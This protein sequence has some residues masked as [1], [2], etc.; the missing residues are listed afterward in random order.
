MEKKIKSTLFSKII[1][2]IVLTWIC[3]HNDDV[4]TFNKLWYNNYTYD[5]KLYRETYRLLSI[6]EKYNN[7]SIRSLKETMPNN[8]FNSENYI[9]NNEKGDIKKNKRSNVSSSKNVQGN[10]EAMKNKSCIFETKS[11]SRLEKN[12]FKEL[13]YVNFLKNNRTI[14]D[15]LYKKILCKIYGLR[16]SLPLVFLLLLS[17][18]FILDYSCG[19]G[20]I[21]GL[22]GIMNLRS[23]E[24]LKALHNRLF[25]SPLKWMGVILESNNKATIVSFFFR[26]L[27][28]YIPL[29]I[30]GI[31]LIL[32]IFY[33]HKK[34]IK[35]QKIKY[36]KR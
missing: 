15:E 36:R 24:W 5:K 16:L 12:L 34:V 20:L 30:L 29:I 3:H 26:T 11:Y 35:Y 14:S 21:N 1:F 28:Y 33:Y 32:M 23:K 17:I 10:K 31:T 27:I 25:E 19:Y 2:F 6:C 4:S 18:L 9:F 13:D 8:G 7:S 22:F